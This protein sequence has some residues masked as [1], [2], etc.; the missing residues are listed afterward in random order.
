MITRFDDLFIFEMANNHQGQVSHG[1]DIIDAMARVARTNGVRAAAKLQYRQLD[2]FIHPD[3]RSRRDVKHIPRFLDTALTDADFRKLQ[4]GIRASGMLTVTT[5]FDEASVERC[6]D[7][8]VEILKLASCSVDD[9]PLIEAIASTGKPVIAS[10]GGAS[11]YQIDDLVSFFT[12]RDVE[13]ALLHCVGL[14]PTPNRCQNLGFLSR[15]VQRYPGVTIGYS[16]HEAPDNLTVVGLAVAKGARILERHVGVPTESIQ[17]N[18]YSMNPQQTDAWVKAALEARTLIGADGE[19]TVTQE[20]L[21]S[22]L[23]LKRGVFARRVIRQGEPLGPNDVFFAMPAAAGQTTSGEFGRYRVEYLATRDYAENDAVFEEADVDPM[24][25]IRRIIHDAK[26]LLSEANLVLADDDTIELSHHY[27]IEKFRSVG[28]LLVNVINR[29]YCKKLVVMLPGQR[30]PMHSHVKKE[31]TFQLIWGDLELTLNGI[32]SRLK[33][34][35]K[36]LVERGTW[37]SFSSRGGAIF[38]EVSTTH[39]KNDS[40]YED[41]GI[42]RLDPAQRKTMLEGW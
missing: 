19:K 2:T 22:L 18:N 3:F 37:H 26:G 9:W 39:I 35:Q 41:D 1:L 8:G 24:M 36:V 14:Y 30:H 20:E 31:E 17:L 38:E 16:G 34:G 33:R 25:D 10:T 32:T 4:E 7:H 27:G 12:H 40:F 23:S 21:E 6:I 11:I 5:P 13:F 15:L 42:A 29:E 28:A